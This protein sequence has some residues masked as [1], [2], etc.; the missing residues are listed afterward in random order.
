MKDFSMDMTMDVNLDELTQF[1]EEDLPGLL[2]N[3]TTDFGIAAFCLQAVMDA[4]QAA[5][6]TSA[7]EEKV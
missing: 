2:L 5:K 1:V 3:N 4:I 7:S 6:Q